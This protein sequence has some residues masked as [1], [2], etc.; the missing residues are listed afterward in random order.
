LS[1]K[2]I[3]EKTGYKDS[4]VRLVIRNYKNKAK[5]SR[6][7]AA[8]TEINNDIVNKP[9]HYTTGGV[10]TLDFIEAKDLNYRLGNVVK[11]VVRAGKKHTDPVEDLKKARFYLDREITVR[12]RA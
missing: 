12:E 8:I 9:L 10:E 3:K 4:L 6:I 7:L 2:E 1:V 11:Y 5:P